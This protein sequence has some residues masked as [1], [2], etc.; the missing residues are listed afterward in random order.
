MVEIFNYSASVYEKHSSTNK[1]VSDFRKEIQMEGAAIRDIARH[2]QILDMTP[3]PSA[4]S[5]LMQ[6]N[7]KTC[8]ASF[9]PP[10]N[11]H[12][13]RFSTPYLVPSLGS[14]D[15]QDQD[16]EKISSYLK[17]LTRGKFSYRSVTSPLS[18]KNRHQSD[19]ESTKQEF[20]REEEQEETLIR[21]GEVLLRALDLGIKSSNLLIDYVISRIFQFVQG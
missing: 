18:K 4:L 11:F 21:E 9:S 1:L 2:A 12:K 7:K 17:I 6:T 10:A 16:M 20:D 5:T 3:K 19:Q 8:W 13:Q 15:R 14:P